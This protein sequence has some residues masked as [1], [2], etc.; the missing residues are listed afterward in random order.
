MNK[1]KTY[2]NSTFINKH[3]I[4]MSDPYKYLYLP[5]IK[6]KK[7]EKQTFGYVFMFLYW[8]FL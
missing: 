4:D 2:L 8:S 7:F 5:S 1:E 6:K 3:Y